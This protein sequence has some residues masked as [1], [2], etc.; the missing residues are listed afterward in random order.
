M[1]LHRH[2]TALDLSLEREH[3]TQYGLHMNYNGKLEATRTISGAI[4][5]MFSE[6]KK[7]GCPINLQWKNGED[8]EEEEEEEEEQQQQQRLQESSQDKEVSTYETITNCEDS[9]SSSGFFMPRSPTEIETK[10]LNRVSTCNSLTLKTKQTSGNAKNIHKISLMH[11][12]FQCIRNKL[13]ELEVML[14][15]ELHNLDILR[16]TEHWLNTEEIAT[17]HISNFKLSSHYCRSTFKNG[18]SAIF[19]KE[20]L[21]HRERTQN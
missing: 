4:E 20:H 13:C 21:S 7:N 2:V 16:C 9:C 17:H 5:T 18:G 6:E 11:Q 8:E 14:K 15:N 3:F 1:K 19:V 12:N 10:E